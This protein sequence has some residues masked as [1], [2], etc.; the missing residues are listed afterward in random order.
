[1]SIGRQHDIHHGAPTQIDD[2]FVFARPLTTRL[3]RVLVHDLDGTEATGTY[4]IGSNLLIG[5]ERW[6]IT[7]VNLPAIGDPP[8][9]RI[10]T[11]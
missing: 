7:E 9:A 2:Y 8:L 5:H 10:A 3:I 6:R 1:M 11:D 4:R